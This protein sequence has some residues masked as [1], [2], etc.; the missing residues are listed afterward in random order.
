MDDEDK[1][2][3]LTNARSVFYQ[4][5]DQVNIADDDRGTK[6][7]EDQILLSVAYVAVDNWSLGSVPE[8]YFPWDLRERQGNT[9][10]SALAQGTLVIDSAAAAQPFSWLLSKGFWRMPELMEHYANNGE[11]LDMMAL[12]AIA[13]ERSDTAHL[14]RALR[15]YVFDADNAGDDDISSMPVEMRTH[16]AGC[17][18]PIG[19]RDWIPCYASTMNRKQHL[20]PERSRE[21]AV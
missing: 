12:T 7:I 13:G 14:V 10:L 9:L 4:A 1:R 2:R 11:L 21:R 17:F 18:E 3:F 16:L 6:Q 5:I 19:D 20:S 8:N 15:L